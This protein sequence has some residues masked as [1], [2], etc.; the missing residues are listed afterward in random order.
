MKK[1]SVSVTG[2]ALGELSSQRIREDDRAG[3]LLRRTLF[4]KELTDMRQRR[5]STF[6]F[7]LTALKFPPFF[8]QVAKLR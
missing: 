6:L 1:T 2:S 3:K 8:G 4:P 7:L 5:I